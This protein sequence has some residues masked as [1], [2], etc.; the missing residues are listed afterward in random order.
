MRLISTLLLSLTAAVAIS[1]GSAQANPLYPQI[2][3]ADHATSATVQFF[4][5]FFTAKSQ[6]DVAATMQFFSPELATYTDTTLKMGLDGFDALETTFA[7]YM[8]TWGEG[9]SYPT[10]ILGD[11]SGGS[12]SA[13]VA[14]TDTPELFG[15]ELRILGA[16]DVRDGKIVRWTDYWDSTGFDNA[17]YTR[18]TAEA[19]LPSSLKEEQVGVAASARIR[20]ASER[21]S[22]AF[23]DGD[24]RAAAALF[25]YDAVFED[26]SLRAQI[27]G[28]SGI[29]RY[30]ERILTVAP[31][32]TRSEL[33][34]VV[35][36]DDGGGFEWRAAPNAGVEV[37]IDGRIIRATTVY[38]R[39]LL[40][41]E[42]LRSLAAA[43]LEP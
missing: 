38:D 9:R 43:A 10:R 32:G 30:L 13:L 19:E 26:L 15:G 1:T 36:G 28:R 23:A 16:V 11:L 7:T 4:D 18:Y 27:L 5:S 8:P 29:E 33:R 14:F 41:N 2:T 20:R 21:L 12:G 24:A 35:G 31:F 6:Q 22:R 3:D 34:H 17:L 37:G 40:A 25:T 39:R 42:A